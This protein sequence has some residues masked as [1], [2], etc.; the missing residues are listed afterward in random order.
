MTRVR[1][2]DQHRPY[3][4]LL[5]RQAVLAAADPVAY[6]RIRLHIGPV[7][8]WFAERCSWPVIL[9]RDLV[10]LVKTPAR[11]TTGQGFRWVQSTLDYELFAW[12][13]WY[14]ERSGA[15]Q[16]VLSDLVQ[17]LSAQAVASIAAGHVDW[18][19][20]AHRQALRRALTALEEMGAL[21]RLDGSTETWAAGGEGNSLYE[22][23]SLAQHLHVF[24]PERLYADLAVAG[25][26]AVLRQTVQGAG[27]PAQR[28]YRTLLLAP[29]LYAADDPEAFAL[30]SG[31]DRR[32][33]I[34]RDFVHTFGWDLEVAP[35]YACLLRPAA[36]EVSEQ[37]VFPF[38]GAIG[39]VVLLLC[40]ALREAV[41]AGRIAP[42]PYDRLPLSPARFEAELLAVSRRWGDAWGSSVGRM[43]LPR[44]AEAVA[45]VMC[46]W[47]LLD[48]PD[49]DGRL[50]VLP[51]A[52]RFTGF[53]RDD[54]QGLEGDDT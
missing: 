37:A 19:T 24:L 3:I 36:S 2:P 51:L 41:A 22:F 26:P 20:Y 12:V 1:T 4:D 50:W 16:F 17:E 28:L 44:L 5:D 21:R 39:H 34:A 54:G 43:A 46:D 6:R 30:L 40:A 49:A 15:D 32:R 18:N 48:G 38:R 25:D 33:A 27:G 52:A 10:R 35:A 8:Q 47:G 31:R 29:A 14:G 13:L 11:P 53:Y 23:T 7:R 45:E 9:T 42:D